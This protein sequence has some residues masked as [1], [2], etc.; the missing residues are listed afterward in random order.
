VATR[1]QNPAPRPVNPLRA[2]GWPWPGPQSMEN[3]I[4]PAKSRRSG[5]RPS[6]S[7]EP[8]AA[9]IDGLASIREKYQ[10]RAASEPGKPTALLYLRQMTDVV[11]L[12]ADHY[13]GG[14]WQQQTA[15]TVLRELR[16]CMVDWGSKPEIEA[17]RRFAW[18]AVRMGGAVFVAGVP[19]VAAAVEMVTAPLESNPHPAGLRG[20]AHRGLHEKACHDA[21]EFLPKVGGA[22]MWADAV[23]LLLASEPPRER[24][25]LNA[26]EQAIYDMLA[27]LPPSAAM[28]GPELLNRLLETNPMLRTEQSTLTSRYIPKLRDHYGVES[29]AA[30]YRIKPSMRP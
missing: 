26:A 25:A 24:P 10:Q 23:E 11:D 6:T 20:L 19:I 4:M 16:P 15:A 12:L 7:N 17:W 8:P 22:K 3:I 18:D 1:R 14:K 5:K 30:G 9:I 2:V 27:A 28:K 21:T 29:T 13:I